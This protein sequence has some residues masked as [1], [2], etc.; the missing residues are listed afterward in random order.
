[1]PVHLVYRT[2]FSDLR[3]QMSYRADIYGRDGKLWS[4]LQEA[5][6]SLPDLGS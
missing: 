5:G 2:A 3:G 6:V 1:M 4:A